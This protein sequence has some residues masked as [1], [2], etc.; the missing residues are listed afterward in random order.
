MDSTESDSLQFGPYNTHYSLLEQHLQQ[1][2][3]Q[4]DLTSNCWDQ[5]LSSNQIQCKPSNISITPPKDFHAF[6][7]PFI[8]HEGG[9]TVQKEHNTADGVQHNPIELPEE[10]TKALQTTKSVLVS[11]RQAIE[12]ARLRPVEQE[13]LQRQIETKFQVQHLNQEVRSH[14]QEWLVESGN[15]QQI[16]DLM[17][18]E[19]SNVS[20]SKFHK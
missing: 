12:D 5:I 16:Q 13:D 14:C 20:P 4:T 19:K 2:G 18:L 17:R 9:T 10:Y 15:I 6:A 11:L 7:V 3:L 1:S 8:L